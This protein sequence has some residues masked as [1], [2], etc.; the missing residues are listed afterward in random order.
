MHQVSRAWHQVCQTVRSRQCPIRRGRTFNN[1]YVEMVRPRVRRVLGE[2][3]L[4][5]HYDLLGS[6]TRFAI[7]GPMRPG[8][9]L[10]QRLNALGY[11]VVQ[12]WP[13]R[14]AEGL[15]D[16]ALRLD[17]ADLSPDPHVVPREQAE[18]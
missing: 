13:E 18:P 6:R 4:E 10:E 8:V 3:A 17:R 14:M 5:R 1:M 7:M 15:R 12:I 2:N 9:E 11:R 16:L